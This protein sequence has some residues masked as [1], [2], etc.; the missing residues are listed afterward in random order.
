M[1]IKSLWRVNRFFRLLFREYLKKIPVFYYDLFY[2]MPT[3]QQSDIINPENIIKTE[4]MILEDCYLSPYRGKDEHDD[5]T[6]IH[7]LVN[8]NRPKI[9]VELGTALGNTTA[10]ICKQLPES[11]VYTVCALPD[12]ISG[13][14]I[15]DAF[16]KEQIGRVY[17]EYGYEEQVT[18]IYTDTIDMDLSENNIK[19]ESVDFAIIDACHD[20]NYVYNDFYK[21]LPYVK[22]GGILLFHDTHTKIERHFWTSYLAC[23]RI[24]KDGYKIK[25]VKGTWYGYLKKA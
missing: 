10:N 7:S 22:K 19:K 3:I 5:F 4:E 24:I 17:R 18:Q 9:I 11:K 25:H 14:H 1:A 13:D 23:L 20:E 6:F 2:E 15:T 21:V 8:Q 16:T 12:Q